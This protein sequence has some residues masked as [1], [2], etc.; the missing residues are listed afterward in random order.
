MFKLITKI[1]ARC[2]GE[3]YSFILP[4]NQFGFTTGQNITDC[5]DGAFEYFNTMELPSWKGNISLKI[6]ICQNFDIMC[7][8][9]ILK[10]M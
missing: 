10:V 6:D 4:Q 9:F 5:K 1:V 2:S 8:V 7:W 3:I